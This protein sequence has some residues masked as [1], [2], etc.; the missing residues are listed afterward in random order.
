MMRRWRWGAVAAML[1]GTL[2]CGE[3]PGQ[4]PVVASAV[5]S[6]STN[7]PDPLQPPADPAPIEPRPNRGW[8]DMVEGAISRRLAETGGGDRIT[9]LDRTRLVATLA[10]IRLAA[11][12]R[13]RGRPAH[14]LIAARRQQMMA[15]AERL[16]RDQLGIGIQEFLD[17]YVAQAE[18]DPTP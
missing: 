17:T 11:R 1:A 16:F 3:E 12:R 14:P 2:G 4:A 10:R 6:T 13:E 8:R 9:D 18:P 5:T 15:D 7:P